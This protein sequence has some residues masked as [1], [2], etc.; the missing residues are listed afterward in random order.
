[1]TIVD[2]LC[3]KYLNKCAN[4]KIIIKKLFENKMVRNVQECETYIS[5]RMFSGIS[6][7]IQK[8]KKLLI[9]KKD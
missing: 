8:M 3:L 5:T 4:I 2:A 7:T 1:M 9:K 6:H